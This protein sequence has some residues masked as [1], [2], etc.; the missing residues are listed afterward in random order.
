MEKLIDLLNAYEN[1]RWEVI[2]D[3]LTEEEREQW[4][5]IEEKPDWRAYCGHVWHINANTVAYDRYTFDTFVISR[6]YWFIRWLIEND[7]INLK[8][9]WLVSLAEQLWMEVSDSIVYMVLS[10]EYD[11][12]RRLISILN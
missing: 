11:P 2:D 10:L 4:L 5:V 1:E 12:I 8:A 9:Q 6:N 3:W 7:K